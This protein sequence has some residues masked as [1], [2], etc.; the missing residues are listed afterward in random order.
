L[1]TLDKILSNG[2]FKG[3]YQGHMLGSPF[4]H[5]TGA[6]YTAYDCAET[7]IKENEHVRN[8][9]WTR[10]IANLPVPYNSLEYKSYSVKDNSNGRIDTQAVMSRAI[11]RV[12]HLRLSVPAHKPPLSQVIYGDVEGTSV[13]TY[14]ALVVTEVT[15][16]A[17]ACSV[18]AIWKSWFMVLWLV[19]LILKLMSAFLAVDRHPLDIPASALPPQPVQSFMESCGQHQTT[20]KDEEKSLLSHQKKFEI[21]GLPHGFLIIEGDEN[22]ILQFFR[23]YGHPIRNS[24]CEYAQIIIIIQF[25]FIFPIGLLCSLLWM[26]VGLQYVWMSYQLY[27]T[28]AMHVYRYAGGQKWATTEERIA[29]AFAGAAA[30]GHAQIAFLGG[31]QGVLMA[32]LEVTYHN[33]YRDGQRYFDKLL[34]GNSPWLRHAEI[35][36]SV[37]G[38]SETLLSAG[39]SSRSVTPTDTEKQEV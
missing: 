15:G 38:S 31:R 14:L 32:E 24:F 20:K 6:N 23:H 10:V 3:R 25:G 18:M 2:L 36:N 17:V 11:H 26:P 39:D 19:P 13:Q 1:M 30:K 37:Q 8:G 16:I 35:L 34:H 7:R 9:F 33:R 22:L 12:S 21:H 29:K 4:Y 27:A 5:D 28:C